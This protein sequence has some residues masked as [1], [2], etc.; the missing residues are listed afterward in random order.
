M[1]ENETDKLKRLQA[2]CNSSQEISMGT[3]YEYCQ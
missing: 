2:V 1:S 3:V